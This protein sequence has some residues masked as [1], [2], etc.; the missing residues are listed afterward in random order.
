MP[1]YFAALLASS[2]ALEKPRLV[3]GLENPPGGGAEGKIW[4]AALIVPGL[5]LA[6]GLVSL[7]IR[8]AGVYGPAATGIVICLLLPTV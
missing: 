3:R 8:R 4:L 7:A 1:L 5:L 2:L 6:S